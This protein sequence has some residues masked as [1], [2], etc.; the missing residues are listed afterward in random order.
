MASDLPPTSVSAD[1][2]RIFKPLNDR[3]SSNAPQPDRPRQAGRPRGKRDWRFFTIVAPGL[4]LVAGAALA[5]GYGR[6]GEMPKPTGSIRHAAAGPGSVTSAGNV[7]DRQDPS[8][9]RAASGEQAAR[10]AIAPE[11]GNMMPPPAADDARSTVSE[12][13]VASPRTPP[14]DRRVVRGAQP[15]RMV[16]RATLARA[17]PSPRQAPSRGEAADTAASPQCPPGSLEDRCIYQDVLNADARLRRAYRRARQSGV[18][19]GQLESINR[20]WTRA[21]EAAQDDPDGTIQRYDRLTGM[22]DRARQDGGE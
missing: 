8:G 16:P 17:N 14:V 2:D 22:L 15:A 18:P 20:Q 4:V 9:V 7:G 13:P 11:S 21:R 12:A 3:V 19:Y 1:M 10:P 6:F 5:V